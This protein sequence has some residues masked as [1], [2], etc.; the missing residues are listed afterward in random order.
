MSNTPASPLPRLLT[1]EEV[2]QQLG[3]SRWRVYELAKL[4]MPHVRLGRAV[5]FSAD[6]LREWLAAGGTDSE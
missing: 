4:G 5:R 2:A 6:A 3:L 1:A